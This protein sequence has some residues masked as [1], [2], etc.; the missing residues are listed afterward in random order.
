MNTQPT[1]SPSNLET[2]KPVDRE[3][4]RSLPGSVV[5]RSLFGGVLMGLANL[6]PGISGGTMLLAAGIY[7]RFIGAI[8]EVTRFRFRFP[9]LLILF[10]V[11]GAAALSILLCAG[12]LKDLVLSHRWI[13]YSL[14]IGLTWGGIPV[15]W[16]MAKPVSPSLVITAILSLLAM[17]ALAILQ[18]NDVVGSSHTN[19]LTLFVAGLAGACA[20]ILPGLS[21]GYI[22]L[23]LGQYVPI[24]SGIDQFKDA[25]KAKD[26]SSAIDPLLSI[27]LPVGIGVIAGVVLIGNLLQWLLKHYQKPTLGLL[28]GLLIGST[29]GLYPFQTGTQPEEIQVGAIINGQPVT[30]EDLAELITS[31]QTLPQEDW[32]VQY[33]TPSLEQLG[34]SLGWIALGLAITLGVAKIGG[35]NSPATTD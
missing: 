9:S 32:P 29:A 27:L 2:N 16:K 10:C 13:M 35:A 11:S 19:A 28:L 4:A 34:W 18:A 17:V 26:M 8:A 7:P 14:F 20:M 25:L 24:L 1:S 31:P 33:F 12:F 15:V 23:L 5:G 3:P 22:L 30:H 6:V 21:G